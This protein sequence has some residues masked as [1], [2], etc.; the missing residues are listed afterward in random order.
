[1]P[2][3]KHFREGGSVQS[4]SVTSQLSAIVFLFPSDLVPVVH[5]QPHTSSQEEKSLT[6]D[7]PAEVA[8]LESEHQTSAVSF[9]WCWELNPGS[10]RKHVLHH[11]TLASLGLFE[12]FSSSQE[13]VLED[14]P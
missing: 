12:P 11:W 6:R 9:S 13:S 10:S 14:I 2:A 7:L 8:E 1:M 3:L 5:P 4:Y